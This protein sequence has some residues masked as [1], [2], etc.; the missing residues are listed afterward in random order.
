[1]TLPHDAFKPPNGTAI[2]LLLI[3]D[4]AAFSQVMSKRLAL[5]GIRTTPVPSGSQAVL[6]LR[7]QDFDLAILDLKMEDMDGIEVLKIFKKMVPS[8]PVIMLTGHGC[9][10]SAAEGL[11]HGASEYLTKPCLLE[12]LVERIRHWARQ[13]RSHGHPPH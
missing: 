2:D 7:A 6:T 5:R 1:M 10:H 11:R 8:M 13:R 9:D 4:E 3:D 12:E